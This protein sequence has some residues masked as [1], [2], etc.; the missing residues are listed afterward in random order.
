MR[1]PLELLFSWLPCLSP[2]SPAWSSAAPCPPVGPPAPPT[3]QPL[4]PP[5]SPLTVPA[6][7]LAVGDVWET[8]DAKFTLPITN[9]TDRTLEVQDFE[10]SCDCGQIAPRRLTLPPGGT[11][12]VTVAMD[13][14]PRT[15]RQLGMVRRQFSTTV[16][17]VLATREKVAPLTI[18]G[19]AVS[20]VTANYL[21]VH[22]GDSNAAGRPPHSR[23]VFL[24][25]HL[26]L[27]G[28]SA[29]SDSDSLTAAV[30]KLPEAD[31]FQ[32]LL[33]PN[34]TKQPGPFAATVT[35]RPVGGRAPP[36]V[37]L[38]LPVEGTLAQP[39]GK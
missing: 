34:T 3:A 24:T 18:Q 5:P 25:A 9:T 39:E 38:A 27:D 6:D 37:S 14:M 21:H 33:T 36:A 17:P 7:K 2:S 19:V 8:K 30:T 26:P 13:L 31:K 15:T 20:W 22:F 29:T 23:R 32:L 28:I 12:E 4:P 16:T 1:C 11:A 35:L 10:S